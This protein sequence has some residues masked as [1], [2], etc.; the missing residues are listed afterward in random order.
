MPRA[1]A[2]PARK[3][4]AR[5]TRAKKTRAAEE[6]APSLTVSEDAKEL[7]QWQES[8][9]KQPAAPKAEFE[10]GG[11]GG[12]IGIIISL[13][14]TIYMLYFGCAQQE[15]ISSVPDAIRLPSL[16]YDGLSRGFSEGG[17]LKLW[18]WE[19]TCIV[20]AW[21]AL[22]FILYLVLPGPTA[23]GVKLQDGSRLNYNMNGHLAFWLCLTAFV[24]IPAFVN[25]SPHPLAS[26]YDHYLEYITASMALS[27]VISVYCYAASFRPGEL[28]AAGGQTGNPIYDFFIGRSLNPRIG[29]LDLKVACELR[30]GLIG[31]TLLNIGMAAKQIQLQG[32]V[33]APMACVN[34]F[35]A[36][37]V[38]DALFQ[39]QAILTTMDVTTD[40]FGFMLAFG[41]LAWVPFT[42]S[43]Q[44]RILVDHDPGL[45]SVALVAITA[46][47]MLG[48]AV[49][50]GANS[51][52][53]A[54]RRDPN[55]PEVAHLQFLNTE[56]G[57]KLLI[58]GWWGLARKINYT[59]DWMMGLAWCLT[60]GGATPLAYFYAIYFAVLLIHRSFRDDHMCAIKY[61]P[62][63]KKY[64]EKVPAVFIPGV[65]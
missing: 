59:G 15:C 17:D 27:T 34:A 25:Q 35:Q 33:S 26:L 52:K 30:P 18:S 45:S 28:L 39:E 55:S 41:D 19:V 31:W 65:F 64:K 53:D 36:L 23:P 16:L 1:A 57:T 29:E 14:L 12:A 43:L 21:A 37:Y 50:R 54:F 6:P 47:N 5:Q 62:D 42:Y 24:A 38:W 3:S 9:S 46:L 40:G 48:Y 11:P 58:T 10:F 8:H 60:C 49:F 63:W 32:Y 44:A 13:P 4:P 2:S 7:K 56:R 20:F 51:Q 61:G 22:H